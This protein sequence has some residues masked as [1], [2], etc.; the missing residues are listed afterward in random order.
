MTSNISGRIVFLDY[1]RVFAF[2]S[3]LI[4]HKLIEPLQAFIGDA[5]QHATLRLIAELIYPL[6][7]GGAAGVVV[8]FLT[9]GYII[10]HVLQVE[11]PLEFMIK[12]IFR[13]YPLYTIAVILE[14]YM[15]NRLN[16][17]PLPS[18]SVLA[19][20]LML[21]GDFFQTPH[22]LAGVE[23]TL[24][25]EIMFYVFMTLLKILGGFRNQTWLPWTM[26]ASACVLYTL[27]QIPG[28]VVWVHGYFTLYAPFLLMGALIY[29]I[30]SG[31]AN[32]LI[33]VTAIGAMFVAFLVLISKFHPAWSQ[34]HY[35][36]LALSIFLAGWMFRSR[37][38]DGKVLRGASNLT[39]SVYLFH[40]WLWIYLVMLVKNIP[41]KVFHLIFRLLWF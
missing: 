30:E 21:I 12:R 29:L 1:M 7:L 17:V 5:T 35:G 20:Q 16:G 13:I 6:C 37:L 34:V 25:I 18:L 23:W 31:G 4:G 22:A 24:R 8:F 10:T 11:A 39:Y 26:F 9:S 14:W 40:N 19:P 27:P 2:M 15:W 28:E 38:P 3:V 41:L 36:V 33:C 32:K